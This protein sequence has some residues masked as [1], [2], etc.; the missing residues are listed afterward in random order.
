MKP[1]LP[2]L[3]ALELSVAFVSAKFKPRDFSWVL[4]NLA[5]AFSETEQLTPNHPAVH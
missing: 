5:S 2:S 1:V 3:E 4:R